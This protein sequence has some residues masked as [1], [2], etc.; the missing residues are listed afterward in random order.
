MRISWEGSSMR[1]GLPSPK[2]YLALAKLVRAA[3]LGEVAGLSI[4]A[5][6]ERLLLSSP[7]SY[8][9]TVRHMTGMSAGEFRRAL[10]GAAALERFTEGLIRP[11][12]TILRSFDPFR[13]GVPPAAASQAG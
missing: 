1:A 11:Y 7:Q 4:R 12:R 10:N 8:C 6:S 9:R 2:Q 3:Y 13:V 5:I